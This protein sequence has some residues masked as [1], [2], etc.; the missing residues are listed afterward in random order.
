MFLCEQLRHVVEYCGVSHR[1]FDVYRCVA[2][3]GTV[4][5]TGIYLRLSLAYR[6]NSDLLNSE[7]G[8]IVFCTHNLML[9]SLM[10]IGKIR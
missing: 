4:P 3:V 9:L 10:Q 2:Y 1:R 7:S 8:H 6:I 5:C